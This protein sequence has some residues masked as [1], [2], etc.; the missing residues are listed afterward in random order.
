MKCEICGKV[1]GNINEHIKIFHEDTVNKTFIYCKICGKKLTQKGLKYHITHSHK[2]SD[3]DYYDLYLKQPTEAKCIKCRK[4]TE[5]ISLSQ[6]YKKYCEQC[7]I[8][9]HAIKCPIC[10]MELKNPASHFYKKHNISPKEY[11]DTY[12]KKDDEGICAICGNPTSFISITKGY[13]KHCSNPSC[14]QLD[15]EI[16]KKKKKTCL[17][18]YGVEN[19]FQ[20]P[21]V[22]AKAQSTESKKKRQISYKKTCIERY[23]VDNTQKVPEIRDKV[24]KTNKERYGGSGFQSPKTKDT[25]KARYG[26]ENIFSSD[27]GKKRIKSSNITNNGGMG[28]QSDSIQEK[29]KQTKLER[30]ND[31]N[32]HNTDQ[33]WQTRKENDIIDSTLSEDD[34]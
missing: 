31:E 21:E 33:L 11:Y 6:G 25:L 8:R 16:D 5:F 10:N 30:Y 18:R 29:I 34:L 1:V 28:F 17:E 32:Y 24:I 12:L 15:P 3:K 4:P 7:I 19:N 14:A 27:Y 22:I 26:T 2:I 23:G 13:T 9:P 20:R